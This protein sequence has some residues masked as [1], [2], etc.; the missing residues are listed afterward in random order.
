[1]LGI[2]DDILELDSP[3]SGYRS[4]PSPGSAKQSL[5]TPGSHATGDRND[6]AT[7]S[8]EMGTL[9]CSIMKDAITEFIQSDESRE[10][11]KKCVED[12]V[13][14]VVHNIVGSKVRITLS[15]DE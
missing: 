5:A 8:T 13:K 10:H 4:M 1:M 11:L 15:D 14:D 3:V 12:A 6:V 2:D 7:P 9:L